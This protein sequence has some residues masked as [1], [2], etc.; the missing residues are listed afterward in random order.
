MKS[1][2]KLRIFASPENIPVFAITR[3][4][5]R[6]SAIMRALWRRFQTRTRQFIHRDKK[7]SFSSK[8]DVQTT[9][10]ENR[11]YV[12]W[13]CFARCADSE[14]D[15]KTMYNDLREQNQGILKFLGRGKKIDA[16]YIRLKD[17]EAEERDGHVFHFANGATVFWG[18]PT[19]QREECLEL[20]GKY[21]KSKPASRAIGDSL[22]DEMHDFYCQ[23]RAEEEPWFR[24]DII[25]LQNWDDLNPMLTVSY[26]LA[27]ST[28]LE[29]IT[30]RVDQLIEKNKNVHRGLLAGTPEWTKLTLGS[31][32]RSV[33]ELLEARFEINIASDILDDPSLLWEHPELD[34]LFRET[35]KE[36]RLEKRKELLNVRLG[37]M[38]DMLEILNNERQNKIGHN[39]E[40]Y[41]IALIAVEILI[42]LH[43]YLVPY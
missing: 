8:I 22:V 31:I 11:D 7:F 41:I 24:E 9:G 43:A 37:I 10:D 36:V 34:D 19:S 16:V 23:L 4:R 6:S 12:A 17:I 1:Y 35:I 39:L 15:M 14:I 5:A 3:G 30:R 21:Q 20:V 32:R 25:V 27:K 38:K 33:S 28:E 26:G 2:T 13:G 42:S 18:V 29:L 40:W